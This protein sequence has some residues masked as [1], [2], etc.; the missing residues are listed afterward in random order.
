ML[1]DLIEGFLLHREAEG[2]SPKTLEYHRTALG[3]FASWV[4]AHDLPTDPE[5]WDATLI[6]RYLVHLRERPAARGARLSPHSVRCYATSLFAFTRWLALEEITP[7]NAA[8]RVAQPKTPHLVK[9]SF[10]EADVKRLVAAA[11][12]DKRNGLRDVALIYFMLDTGCR[13][14]E[15][16]GLQGDHVLWGQRLGKVFGKG[17]KERVVPF[18]AQTMC[19]MQ[20]YGMTKRRSDCGAFFQTEE[21][22]PLTTNGLLCI[23]K[24]VGQRA[25]VGNVH[26]HRFRHTFALT[27]LRS[28]GNVLALQRILGHTTLAMTQRYVALVSDDL[29]A[30]HRE[31][32]PIS[33]LFGRQR[34]RS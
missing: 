31:H 13:A 19:A 1:N 27:F 15:V 34:N 10:S 33:S 4:D 20:K 22:R 3:L 30:A 2:R 28:G 23:T 21:G 11:R 7:K 26:S 6:R 25:G 29:V 17:G 12:V 9:E 5:A 16:C 32:S 24:K 18:S 14:A 8:E